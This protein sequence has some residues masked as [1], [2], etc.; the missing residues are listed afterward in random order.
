MNSYKGIRGYRGDVDSIEEEKKM[1]SKPGLE[2]ED[3]GKGQ[4]GNGGG[5]Q[6]KGDR[7]EEHEASEA[8]LSL[9]IYLP[10]SILKYYL[11]KR[12]FRLLIM[13][14]SLKIPTE[15]GIPFIFGNISAMRSY[16]IWF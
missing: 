14:R 4:D 12:Q 1:A 11:S 9:I 8:I 7:E 15:I 6:D 10:Q 16:T 3:Q 13:F 5:A 2:Q